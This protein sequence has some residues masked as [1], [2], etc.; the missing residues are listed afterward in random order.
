MAISISLIILII[1]NL[2]KSKINVPSSLNKSPF[3]QKKFF[4]VRSQNRKK[5]TF[6]RDL[7]TRTHLLIYYST[8]KCHERV[9]QYQGQRTPE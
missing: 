9:T 2:K 7:R 5:Y 3:T 6:A 4:D 8:H 1:K